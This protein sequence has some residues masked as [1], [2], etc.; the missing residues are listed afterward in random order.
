MLQDTTDNAV[1]SRL[2]VGGDARQLLSVLSSDLRLIY[3]DV[4]P[5]RLVRYLDEMQAAITQSDPQVIASVLNAMRLAGI[6]DTD[7]VDFYVPVVAR[8]L[9]E[10][11]SDDTLAFTRVSVGMANLQAMLHS[12]DASWYMPEQAP[13]GTLGEMC[14]IVPK[15][16]QHSFGSI[17]LAGQ[18]RR[19]GYD[20]RL[21]TGLDLD[22]IAEFVSAPATMAVMV[23]ASLHEPLDFLRAVVKKVR[24][25][26]P[27]APVLIGGNVLEHNCDLCA[28]TGADQATSDWQ[29]ALRF[30]ADYVAG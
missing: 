24:A 14:I 15:G 21:G 29:A 16:T 23:S 20:V 1:P 11:W 9:G 3:P 13:F 5:R 28:V 6:R 8:R 26:N 12:L 27:W 7:I 2:S 19:A 4:P 25:G 10:S 17:I 18:V 22:E 30:C